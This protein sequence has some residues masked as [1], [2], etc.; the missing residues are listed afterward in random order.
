MAL[1]ECSLVLL[2]II[3]ISSN[4]IPLAQQEKTNVAFP[5]NTDPSWLLTGIS[6]AGIHLG[7]LAGAYSYLYSSF[8][9][10]YSLAMELWLEES[11]E[12]KKYFISMPSYENPLNHRWRKT[13]AEQIPPDGQ[14]QLRGWW[15]NPLR[16]TP[17]SSQ[18]KMSW[19]SPVTPNILDFRILINLLILDFLTPRQA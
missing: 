8:Q 12:G 2:W 1:L 6:H 4:A 9:S 10:D 11:M 18:D 19:L 16:D 7:S 3:R 13:S 15:G 5:W 17:G 14:L